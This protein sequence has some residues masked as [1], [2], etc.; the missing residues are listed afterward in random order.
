MLTFLVGTTKRE[1]LESTETLTQ[2]G[3]RDS[4]PSRRSEL[5]SDALTGLSMEAAASCHCASP[6]DV[7]TVDRALDA[8]LE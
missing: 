2:S 4:C 5:A 6:L 7:Q 1:F 8:G 3:A